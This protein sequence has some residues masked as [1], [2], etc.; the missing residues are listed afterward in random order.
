MHLVAEAEA[1]DVAKY[2]MIYWPGPCND[3]LTPLVRS[4]KVLKSG[5]TQTSAYITKRTK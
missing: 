2:P 1:E 4:A 3:D 5:Y